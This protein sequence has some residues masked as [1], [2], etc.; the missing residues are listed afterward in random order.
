M[1]QRELAGVAEH[2]FFELCS[3]A[4]S[5]GL[6]D[7]IDDSN[8]GYLI[9]LLVALADVYGIPRTRLNGDPDAE[10]AL[11]RHGLARGYVS[12]W[13]TDKF[14]PY[15]VVRALQRVPSLF[16]KYPTEGMMRAVIRGERLGPYTGCWL[17]QNAADAGPDG[18]Q[19]IA[20]MLDDLNDRCEDLQR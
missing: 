16:A 11:D 14:D 17:K 15:Q 5:R 18:S 19:A 4:L 7:E 1:N 2:R 8:R 3:D 10:T 9:G 13:K 20:Q 12:S 6:G